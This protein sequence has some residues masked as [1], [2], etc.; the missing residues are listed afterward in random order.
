MM[1]YQ[2]NAQRDAITQALMNVASPQPRP[3]LPQSRAQ[4]IMGSGNA[5]SWGQQ[6][7]QPQMPPMPQQQL[8][9]Q[10]APALA[11][12]AAA[13]LAPATGAMPVGAPQP[14]NIGPGV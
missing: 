9:P 12:A 4:A 10:A 1:D 7:Q 13:A 5:Q 14:Q 8:P 11:P 2:H 3:Q 6:G